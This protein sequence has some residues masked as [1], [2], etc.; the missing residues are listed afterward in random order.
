MRN[1]FKSMYDWARFVVTGDDTRLFYDR[2]KNYTPQ[3]GLLVLTDGDRETPVRITETPDGKYAVVAGSQVIQ[4][5]SRK[6]DAI[7]GAERRGI[8]VMA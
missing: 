4:V 3:M 7:R 8:Q 1:F 6:R 2:V 5:Y